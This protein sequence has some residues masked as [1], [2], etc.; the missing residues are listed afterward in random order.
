ML[1]GIFNP[2]LHFLMTVICKLPLFESFEAQW[3]LNVPPGSTL[4]NAN[5]AHTVYLC[6]LYDNWQYIR[7]VLDRHTNG[8]TP[9]CVRQEQYQIRYKVKS[10]NDSK[11]TLTVL[12]RLDTETAVLNC[13]IRYGLLKSDTEIHS[14]KLSLVTKKRHY[15]RTKFSQCGS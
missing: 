4:K 9:F 15:A 5:S 11:H 12:D 14:L 8:N 1:I 13:V 3:S 10:A 6:V 2:R 7:T